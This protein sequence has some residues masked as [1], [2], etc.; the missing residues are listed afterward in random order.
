[1][2]W[3][4]W[5]LENQH[6]LWPTEVAPQPCQH[7]T[8]VILPC[9]QVTHTMGLKRKTHELQCWCPRT[10]WFGVCVEQTS[11]DFFNLA[12]PVSLILLIQLVSVLLCQ[13][14]HVE[15]FEWCWKWLGG[16]RT[17]M[18]ASQQLNATTTT[19]SSVASE[20]KIWCVCMEEAPCHAFVPCGHLGLC[21][22]CVDPHQCWQEQEQEQRQ[23][24]NSEDEEEPQWKCSVCC[25]VSLTV[26]HF[27]SWT[28]ALLCDTNRTFPNG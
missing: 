24:Q 3:C 6:V 19:S 5:F 2:L 15:Q 4:L 16:R 21:A 13:Q 20:K 23:E 11:I 27:F 1:M 18:T 22:G 25:K 8:P 26:K 28:V 7:C 12:V 10:H 9:G 14:F 17:L